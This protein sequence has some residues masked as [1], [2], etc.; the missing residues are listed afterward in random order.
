MMTASQMNTSEENRCN[1]WFAKFTLYLQTKH[2]YL[3]LFG[4]S[5]GKPRMFLCSLNVA[6]VV[7]KKKTDGEGKD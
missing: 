4:A 1:G 7:F 5:P 3:R 6:G 2:T